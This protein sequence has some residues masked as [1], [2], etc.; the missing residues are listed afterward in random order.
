[1]AN[2]TLYIAI[3]GEEEPIEVPVGSTVTITYG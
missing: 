2:A 1:V 3:T